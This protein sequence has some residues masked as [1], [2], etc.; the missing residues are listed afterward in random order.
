M[1]NWI[2]SF[3]M[4]SWPAVKKDGVFT[5]NDKKR[6]KKFKKGDRIIFYVSDTE[7]FCGV[8]EAVSDW[9]ES[10]YEWPDK[11]VGKYRID[12]K[13]IQFG[14]VHFRTLSPKLEFSANTESSKLGSLLINSNGSFANWTTPISDKDLELILNELKNNQTIP[15]QYI[16]AEKKL[17]TKNKKATAI[18]SDFWLVGSGIEKER[19]SMW[20]EFKNNNI[21]GVGWNEI[22]D[23][24]DLSR[25]EIIEKFADN[26]GASGV[27]EFKKIKPNDIIFV[28]DGKAGFFGI[29]KS[30]GEYRFDPKYP[31][32][33]HVIPVEWITTEYIKHK[34]RGGNPNAS[35]SRVIK[36]K[37]SLMKY[38]NAMSDSE[39]KSNDAT[40]R[41]LETKNQ[42]I[43]YGPPG[44]GKTRQAQILAKSFIFGKM[45]DDEFNKSII[46]LIKN[47]TELHGF[48]FIKEAS[49]DNLYSLKNSLKEIRLGFHFSGSDKRDPSPYVG[50]PQ[51]MIDF[52]NKV[53]EQNRFEII[54][55]NSVK[56]YVV[57]PYNIK[58]KFARFSGGQWDASGVKEHSF[59][60][61][62]WENEASIPTRDGSSNNKEENISRYL[63]NLDELNLSNAIHPYGY[64]RIVTFH[65]SY[66]YEEFVEGIKAEVVQEKLS[67]SIDDGIFK[68]I[69][70]DAK[71]NPERKFVLIIDEINRGNI[72]KI[73]GELI[74]LIENDKRGKIF[75]NLAYSKQRFTIPKNVYIIG[76]MNT[77]DRSLVQIDIALRR[78][79]GFIEIMP[80]K[81]I[82]RDS[83]IELAL[84][85]LMSSLNELIL[86]RSKNREFQIGHSYFMIKDKPISKISDLQFTFETEII[87]LLQEYFYQDYNELEKILGSECVDITRQEI[88]KMSKEQF[89][90]TMN[91]ILQKGKT[92][93]QSI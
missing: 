76:T 44:T 29:G 32:N 10:E 71:N 1:S 46:E 59:H 17:D 22:G 72:S 49:S 86:Q 74:T 55:N 23:V 33:H 38:L 88:K 12:L 67:Y 79:F 66:S 35:C 77:A 69:C 24:S 41:I 18:K 91:F 89:K 7:N 16:N 92:H 52:L 26:P 43:F 14:F 87:P 37:E 36:D 90:S 13:P 65:Q 8:F 6:H 84:P 19:E 31:I 54:V 5:D 47:Y 73:F 83:P 50:V 93:E 51:K 21:V 48:T 15:E 39:N 40:E 2:K 20:N 53:P 34:I 63:G 85:N 78:R 57:L 30:V 68:L 60:I 75:V 27:I 62:I 28:N 11:S 70:N 64:V 82:L 81:E 80:N 4:I 56:N 3:N 61:N 9:Y 45:S 58:M 25:K 42:L